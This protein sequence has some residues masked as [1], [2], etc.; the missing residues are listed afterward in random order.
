LAQDV[1]DA[2]ACHPNGQHVRKIIDSFV[3]DLEIRMCPETASTGL[4]LFYRIQN[5]ADYP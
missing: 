3:I 5:A 1:L 2:V 4:D